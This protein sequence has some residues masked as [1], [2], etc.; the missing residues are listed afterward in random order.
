MSWWIISPK[1]EAVASINEMEIRNFIWEN[2]ITRFG[3]SRAIVFNNR[4]QFD[5]DKVQD[6]YVEYGI[7]TR[8]I[9]SL[10]PKQMDKLNPLTSRS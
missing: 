7:Q 4:G 1:A 5:T 3:V 9:V 2:I 8:F 10:K 6:Y